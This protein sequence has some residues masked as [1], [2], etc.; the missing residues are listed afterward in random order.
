ML[1]ARGN[2]G[3]TGSSV[4]GGSRAL[5]EIAAFPQLACLGGK[6]GIQRVRNCDD[7]REHL[8]MSAMTIDE[9]KGLPAYG[10]ALCKQPCGEGA[11]A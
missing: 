6:G 2:L 3:T 1:A 9:F 7:L 11:L 8:R 5:S 4:K 10:L